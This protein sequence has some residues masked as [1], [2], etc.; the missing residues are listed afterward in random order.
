MVTV[1]VVDYLLRVHNVT[2]NT[3]LHPFSLSIINIL[4]ALNSHKVRCDGGRPCS[5]CSRLGRGHLCADRIRGAKPVSTGRSTRRI[6]NTRRTS[7]TSA[8]TSATSAPAAVTNGVTIVNGAIV[9]GN[10]GPVTSTR[11]Q[12]QQ[13]H[14][15]LHMMQHSVQP[16]MQLIDVEV[17]D[18]FDDV[19]ELPTAAAASVTPAPTMSFVAASLGRPLPPVPSTTAPKTTSPPTSY[20]NIK[21]ESSHT[22]RATATSPS[23]APATIVPQQQQQ[24]RDA[25]S[26]HKHARDEINALFGHHNKR[27]QPIVSPR[28]SIPSSNSSGSSSSDDESIVMPI[29]LDWDD[30]KKSDNLLSSPSPSVSSSSSSSLPPLPPLPYHVHAELYDYPDAIPTIANCD[31]LPSFSSTPSDVSSSFDIDALC[32]GSTPL[33]TSRSSTGFSWP[34]SPAT[35][36]AVTK[37]VTPLLKPLPQ[38]TI[39]TIDEA[40]VIRQAMSLLAPWY[41]ICIHLIAY[42]TTMCLV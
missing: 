15:Q 22:V 12:Q 19:M 21:F 17:I 4:L 14:L 28:N 38:S 32:P 31:G 42:L 29:K 40:R 24:Q 5:R 11:H 25:I 41:N 13:Q 3:P 34:A 16:D 39:I 23:P 27:F 20:H 26:G 6:P 8:A 7:P 33:S 2:G 36:A 37:W 35:I 1:L 18:D 9:G 10:G 30:G